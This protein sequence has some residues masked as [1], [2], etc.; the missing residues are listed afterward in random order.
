MRHLRVQDP[1]YYSVTLPKGLRLY[2]GVGEG[3]AKLGLLAEPKEYIAE[4]DR[5]DGVG[6]QAEA[7]LVSVRAAGNLMVARGLA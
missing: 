4:L 2:L 7:V 3:V 1:A 6:E 5:R